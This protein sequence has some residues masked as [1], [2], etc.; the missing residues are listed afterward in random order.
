MVYVLRFRALRIDSREQ[1]HGFKHACVKQNSF[2][3]LNSKSRE[4][5]IRMA[6]SPPQDSPGAKPWGFPSALNLNPGVYRPSPK[7]A[8]APKVPPRPPKTPPRRP[9]VYAYLRFVLVFTYQ[10]DPRAIKN[11]IS[12]WFI[13]IKVVLGQ[14]KKSLNCGPSCE[15]QFASCKLE[16]AGCKLQVVSCEL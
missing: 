5:Y 4:K 9:Q 6:F 15:L 1:F 14:S 13:H 2:N 8:H 3:K 11:I 16:V 10:N 12:Y 7:S